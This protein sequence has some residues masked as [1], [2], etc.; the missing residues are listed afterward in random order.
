ML[1]LLVVL[2]LKSPLGVERF[3]TDGLFTGTATTLIGPTAVHAHRPVVIACRWEL[4]IFRI[5][6]RRKRFLESVII[7]R[8][9]E[10]IVSLSLQV[11]LLLSVLLPQ[12]KL[13][14]IGD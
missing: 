12:H 4:M 10:G 2:P 9:L 13:D 6:L 1:L 5:I 3:G 14:T 8:Q 11:L 7:S